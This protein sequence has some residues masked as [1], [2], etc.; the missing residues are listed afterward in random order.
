MLLTKT[1]QLTSVQTERMQVG[2]LYSCVLEEYL[3]HC[4][5][6]LYTLCCVKCPDQCKGIVNAVVGGAAIQ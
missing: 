4:N 1:G 6:F 3:N 2:I 5:L